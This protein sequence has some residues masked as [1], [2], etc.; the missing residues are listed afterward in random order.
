M[1]FHFWKSY[2]SRPEKKNLL[3]SFQRMT[4][5]YATIRTQ[6][7]NQVTTNKFSWLLSYIHCVYCYHSKHDVMWQDLYF[8]LWANLT[9]RTTQLLHA[10]RTSM[11]SSNEQ[12]EVA[13][14]ALKVQ[15]KFRY[16]HKKFHSVLPSNCSRF[17]SCDDIKWSRL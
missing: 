15:H 3:T 10:R 4:C 12:S 14:T 8:F 6:I 7:Q 17:H 5:S 16:L 9:Q 2:L 11:K 13:S 1:S